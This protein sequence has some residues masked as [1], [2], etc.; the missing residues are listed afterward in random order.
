MDFIPKAKEN[1]LQ[2]LLFD[3]FWTYE[4]WNYYC[5]LQHHELTTHVGSSQE[6]KALHPYDANMILDNIKNSWKQNIFFMHRLRSDLLSVSELTT[7]NKDTLLELK[8]KKHRGFDFWRD[9]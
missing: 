6:K 8:K 1:I 2:S 7:V 5:L 9:G 4:Y 3:S